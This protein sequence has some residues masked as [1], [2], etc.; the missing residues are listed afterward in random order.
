MTQSVL[1]GNISATEINGISTLLSISA[2][3]TLSTVYFEI[4]TNV[5]APQLIVSAGGGI[6]VAAL[7]FWH[8][9]LSLVWCDRWLD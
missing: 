2:N 9:C 1:I 4:A 8:N 3:R 7:I 5:T 6:Q